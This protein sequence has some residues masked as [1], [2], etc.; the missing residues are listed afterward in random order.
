M[1]MAKVQRIGEIQLRGMKGINYTKFVC[2]STV[3]RHAQ[4]SFIFMEMS[5]LQDLG[6]SSDP[7][8]MEG[9]SS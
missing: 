8:S 7:L 4:E 6:P 9:S 1:Q 5:G 3:L 2:L